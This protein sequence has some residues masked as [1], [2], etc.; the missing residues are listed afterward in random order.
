MRSIVVFAIAVFAASLSVAATPNCAPYQVVGSVCGRTAYLGWGIAGLGTDSVITVYAPPGL[1]G[2]VTFQMSQLNSSQGS[3]YTGFFGIMTNM[4]NTTAVL[5]TQANP[6]SFTAQ[7]GQGAYY[8][9]SKTCFNATCTGA[10]PA[11]FTGSFLPNMFSM[12]IQIL[13]ANPADLA[14]VQLPLLTGRFLDSTGQVTLVEQETA[15]EN[16]SNTAGINS[17]NEAGSPAVRYVLNGPD[18]TLAYVTFSVTNTSATQPLT[19]TL[20]ILDYN[21]NVV[22]SAPIPAIPPSGA[23]GYLLIGRTPGDT[24]GFFPS[25]TVLSPVGPEGAFHGTLRVNF[26]GPAIFLA[27]EFIGTSMANLVIEP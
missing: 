1:S 11:S 6:I 13:S 25:S 9:V 2:V 14:L 20:N 16:P 17:L 12:Q 15:V 10:A 4:N 3:A 19:G 21:N 7:P 8:T 27:Q 24:L 5:T 26:S 18:I 22:V 23:A